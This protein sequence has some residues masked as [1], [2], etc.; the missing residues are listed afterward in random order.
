MCNMPFKMAIFLDDY[1]QI[2]VKIQELGARGASYNPRIMEFLRQQVAKLGI[3]LETAR[4]PQDEDEEEDW[5]SLRGVLRT[6]VL[7]MC[8]H[9]AFDLRDFCKVSTAKHEVESICSSIQIYV[10]NLGLRGEVAVA[11]KIDEECKSADSSYMALYLSYIQGAASGAWHGFQVT[12]AMRDELESL[13]AENRQRLRGMH[14]IEEAALQWPE[15]EQSLGMGGCGE[16]FLARW[17]DRDVAVKRLSGHE[18]DLPIEAYA[19]F[20]TEAEFQIRM[21]HPNVVKCL[22]VT[23]SGCIVMELAQSN[24]QKL[25]R[26]RRYLGHVP[27]ES[28]LGWKMILELLAQAAEGLRYVHRRRVVHRDVKSNN[29]LLFETPTGLVVKVGDFGLAVNKL[30]ASRSRMGRPAI[31]TDLWMAPEIHEGQP[32]NFDS[33]VFSFGVVMYELASQDWPYRG[34]SAVQIVGRKRKGNPPCSLPA[35]CPPKL[36]DLLRKCIDPSPIR[37]PSMVDVCSTLKELLK[38]EEEKATY[39]VP[40]GDTAALMS[41]LAH[42][43]EEEM[44]RDKIAGEL[45]CYFPEQLTTTNAEWISLQATELKT[46]NDISTGVEEWMKSAVD[47]LRRHPEDGLTLMHK[48]SED[49]YLEAAEVLAATCDDFSRKDKLGLTPL[50][51]AARNGSTGI[52]RLLLERGALPSATDIGGET[53]LHLAAYQGQLE[54][55]SLLLDYGA[56]LEMQN[57]WGNTPLHVACMGRHFDVVSTLLARGSKPTKKNRAK[58]RPQD[59]GGPH[60]A[61][62]FR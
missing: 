3:L 19:E 23:E 6:A 2:I 21:D 48:V 10:E 38:E 37:R 12:D 50:H 26:P 24:L 11:T 35:D 15:E 55:V 29:F 49:G 62:L 27:P 41:D 32:H 17:N 1:F 5:K 18:D 9:M 51:H 16:V 28:Q 22:A 40:L 45:P 33:D 34:V 61:E 14:I 39:N 54:I 60:V 58:E 13:R 25:C 52:A 4:P 36:K 20:L 8:K 7:L 30:Q 46:S 44:L 47:S 57:N 59:L 42:T 43:F 31:G 53:P 56:D